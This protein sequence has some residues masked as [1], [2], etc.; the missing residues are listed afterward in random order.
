MVLY[1]CL[2]GAGHGDWN[3]TGVVEEDAYRRAQEAGQ[4]PDRVRATCTRVMSLIQEFLADARLS[5]SRLAIVTCGAVPVGPTEDVS[6]LA[7]GAVWGLVR[8]VQSEHPGR[9]LLVDVDGCESSQRALRWLL[10]NALEVDESQVAVRRGTAFVPRIA[11]AASSGALTLPQ[12]SEP[13]RL[14][15]GEARTL[16]SLRL[17]ECPAANMPLGP[18]QVRISV[19]VAGL[20][21]RD[22]MIALGVYP[23][24]AA[25]G[26]EGAGVILAVAPDVTDLEPGDR[27][28][29]L[30]PGMLGPVVV[31]DR[32]HLV[33]MPEEWS[34]VQAA[35]TPIAFLTAYYGLVDLAGLMPGE[36]VLVHSAAGGVGMAAVQLAKHFGGEVLAT[37]SPEKWETLTEMGLERSHVASSRDLSFKQQ[38]L[39]TTEE[40]GVDVVLNSLAHDFVDA[41]LDLMGGGGRFVE[42]GKTDIRDGGQIADVRP[43]V[44][45][46]AFD[47]MDAGSARIQEM[48]LEVLSMFARGALRPLPVRACDVRYASQALRIMSQARHVGKVALTMPEPFFDGREGTVL[49]TGGTGG[50]G[51]EVARHMVREHRVSSLMLVS[52]SGAQADGVDEL[53]GELSLEGAQ[54]LTV[55]CDVSDRSQIQELIASVP[56][57]QPLRGVI[58]AA[59][60]LDDGVFEKLTPARMDSVLAPKVDG[61][62]HL[63]EV[64]RDLDLEMFALFSSVSSVFGAPGQGNYAAAN[65]FLDALAS[66]RCVEGRATTS[67]AWGPWQ[68]A[69]GMTS[70]LERLDLTRIADTGMVALSTEQGLELF[71][72]AHAGAHALVI[73]VH[74]NRGTLRRL[75]RGE[76]V[77]PMMRGLIQ[78]QTRQAVES[79]SLAQRLLEMPEGEREYLLLDLVRTHAAMVLGHSSSEHMPPQRP[80]KDLGLDS[81]ASVELRNRLSRATGLRLP[82]TLIFD[83]PTPAELA[84]YIEGLMTDRGTPDFETQ[85]GVQ[86]KLDT[87]ERT[88]A[89]NSFGNS[90]HAA[91]KARLEALLSNLSCASR[92]EGVEDVAD[93]DDLDTATDEELF[94][95]IDAE[96]EVS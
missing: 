25:I 41:S 66:R 19:R 27:V 37:A 94:E 73:P 9:I 87:L 22:V 34:F 92:G 79:R 84:K 91:I 18:G 6:D 82:A 88:L 75:A 86:A 30:L 32:S 55:A 24:E 89:S 20:N 62:W 2:P 44:E 49:I 43:G 16:D 10:G 72:A 67:M 64:T 57:E 93:E 95:L 48:L 45:Y 47:L 85:R 59:G 69:T 60:I 52:R 83:Q 36:R 3:G 33:R 68:K 70:H 63:H 76:E 17:V 71:D 1:D 54:V 50:L 13:W 80:F 78:A 4:T 39:Q 31:A 28:M 46:K 12:G 5:D 8:S 7:G 21:F 90:E 35:T 23:G 51:A 74:M 26:S 15:P 29:G 42:M 11:R 58:H 81:L 61:A 56:P 14:D 53:V 38:F 77:P 96:I 40:Q 65:A